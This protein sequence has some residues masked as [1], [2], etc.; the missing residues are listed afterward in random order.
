MHMKRLYKILGWQQLPRTVC[1]CQNV[2]NKPIIT[3]T[4]RLFKEITLWWENVFLVFILQESSD[5][6]QCTLRTLG[7]P[8]SAEPDCESAV[9]HSTCENQLCVCEL[10]YLVRFRFRQNS[11]LSGLVSLWKDPQSIAFVSLIPCLRYQKQTILVWFVPDS[12]NRTFDSPLHH[13]IVRHWRHGEKENGNALLASLFRYNITAL[14]CAGYIVCLL[15]GNV[16]ECI[17]RTIDDPCGTN[18][19]CSAAVTNSYCDGPTGACLCEIQYKVCVK[20]FSGEEGVSWAFFATGATQHS[21]RIH[22]FPFGRLTWLL[23]GWT[24]QNLLQFSPTP[25]SKRTLRLQSEHFTSANCRP[26]LKAQAVIW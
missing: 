7:D 18:V 23:L 16:T 12:A 8:C 4:M 24:K 14:V 22:Y 11:F 10:G 19:D 1:L 20:N 13:S 3:T 17:L 5:L 2:F 26:T 21:E 15:Q 6:T 25:M 9:T